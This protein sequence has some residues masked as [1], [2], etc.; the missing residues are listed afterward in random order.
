MTPDEYIGRYRVLSNIGRGSMGEVFLALDEQLNRR[1]AI[2]MLAAEHHE[3][4]D[5]L[6]RFVTEARAQAAL[7]HP[8]VAQVYS[9]EEYRGLPFLVIE[10]VD[11]ADTRTILERR[12]R[13]L[14]D[15]EVV[16][17]AVGAA[18]GLREAARLGIVH[19]D[20]KPDNLMVTQ[21]REVKVTDFG[22]AKNLKLPGPTTHEGMI[23]GT[24]DYIAP[25]QARGERIDERADVY[26]LG[27]SMFHLLAGTPPFRLGRPDEDQ[28]MQVI[29]R[30]IQGPT[31]AL[32]EVAPWVDRR[33]AELCARM[34]STVR[35]DRPLLSELIDSLEQLQGAL[36]GAPADPS[37]R[38]GAADSGVL[39]PRVATARRGA[40]AAR[41][42]L[43]SQRTELTDGDDPLELDGGPADEG[44][45]GPGA[46]GSSSSMP[47]LSDLDG[48]LTGV[49]RPPLPAWLRWWTV[50]SV[51]YLLAA[52]VTY[53][54]NRP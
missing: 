21:R 40:R 9:I 36:E 16:A 3:S 22:L 19:R 15:G 52:T 14:E 37:G 5:V 39:S 7:S 11:G 25:E 28:P 24:P 41:W 32:A 10:A 51:L 23:L 54:A 30:R 34:M 2:K 27:C 17:I 49:L 29:V 26:A 50:L 31:P 44:D 48:V 35:E 6:E 33:V 38:T 53:L 45:D 4:R 12:G 42:S 13:P 47:T 1:V 8:N 20:V 46:S 43:G 18:R